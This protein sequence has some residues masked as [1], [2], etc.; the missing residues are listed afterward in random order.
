M[1]DVLTD[2]AFL[3]INWD[4]LDDNWPDVWMERPPTRAGGFPDREALVARYA[5]T[6]GLD[7]DNLDYHRAFAYWRI[8]VLAEGIKRRYESG[9]MAEHVANSAELDRRVQARA[10]LAE[11]FLTQAGG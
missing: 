7:V 4:G 11:R 2:L 1:G 6:T 3:L 5:R 9:A 8:A 10:Q